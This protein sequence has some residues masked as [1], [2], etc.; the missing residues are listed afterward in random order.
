M[1]V[2]IYSIA[3]FLL[4]TSQRLGYAA[5][6]SKVGLDNFMA[7]KHGA[8]AICHLLVS[9]H[10]RKMHLS[11]VRLTFSRGEGHFPKFPGLPLPPQYGTLNFP[12]ATPLPR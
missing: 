9:V 2:C 5:R 1:S 6:D 10:G 7:R 3:I 4:F 11:H 12:I 8:N